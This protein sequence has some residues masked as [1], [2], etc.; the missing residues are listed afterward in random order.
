MQF[1]GSIVVFTAAFPHAEVRGS[2]RPLHVEHQVLHKWHL[3]WGEDDLLK[4]KDIVTQ[5]N[6]KKLLCY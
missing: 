1:T 6:G 3:I 5:V 4:K 2:V